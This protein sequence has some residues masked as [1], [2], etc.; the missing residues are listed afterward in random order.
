[1]CVLFSS[2][3]RSTLK[4]NLLQNKQNWLEIIEIFRFRVY[5][6]MVVLHYS[7]LLTL[8]LSL[9]HKFQK[10]NSL[11]LLQ[12]TSNREEKKVNFH[13]TFMKINDAL[14]KNIIYIREKKVL[15]I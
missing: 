4:L 6:L 5:S 15:N 13:S 11:F 14:S 7:I 12:H 1:M 2:I 8:S 9:F 10:K 3:F